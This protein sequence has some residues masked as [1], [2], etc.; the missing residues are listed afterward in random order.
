MECRGN[1]SGAKPVVK[2]GRGWLYCGG[3]GMVEIYN[4]LEAR[5]GDCGYVRIPLRCQ[6][7]S[8]GMDSL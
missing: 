7:R 4:P 1:L 6:G 8:L 5:N 2:V 3:G